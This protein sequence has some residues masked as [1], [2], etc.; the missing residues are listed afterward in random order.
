MVALEVVENRKKKTVVKRQVQF[1]NREFRPSVI[2]LYY[3]VL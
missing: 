3:V 2:Q 1:L